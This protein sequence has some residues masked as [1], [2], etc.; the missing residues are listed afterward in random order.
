MALL[1]DKDPGSRQQSVARAANTGLRT[2]ALL[3]VLTL[4]LPGLALGIP[5]AG[6]LLGAALVA[7]AVRAFR[8]RGRAMLGVAYGLGPEKR[9]TH[10]VLSGV[11]AL[12]GILVVMLAVGSAVSDRAHKKQLESERAIAGERLARRKAELSTGADSIAEQIDSTLKT[13]AVAMDKGS[14][15]EAARLAR[16][17]GERLSA[18]ND[19]APLPEQITSVKQR[20]EK[21]SG[22]VSTALAARRSGEQAARLVTSGDEKVKARDFIGADDDYRHAQETYGSIPAGNVKDADAVYE[23]ATAG[24]RRSSIKSRLVAAKREQLREERRLAKE[25][26]EAAALEALCGS[27]PTQSPWNGFVLAAKYYLE[28]RLNDPDSFKPDGCTD[29]R[30]TRRACWVTTCRFRA[31]NGFGGMIVQTMRFSIGAPTSESISG[32][33]LEASVV[34]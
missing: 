9:K 5:L 3:G 33:V 14:L 25:R 34:E 10:A 31:K 20:A 7:L 2:V 8:Q 27:K 24:Q 6:A 23:Q 32:T 21:F 1:V 30:L 16:A 4:V 28:E 17:I 29:P 18:Y 11:E 13:A 15:D 26:A 22:Q 19:V 12:L